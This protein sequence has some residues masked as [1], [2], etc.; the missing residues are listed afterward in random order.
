MSLPGSSGPDIRVISSRYLHN[1]D[2]PS[3]HSSPNETTLYIAGP[4]TRSRAKQLEKIIHSQVNANLMLN[5]QITLNEHMLLSTCFNVLRNG[6]L[7]E[8]AW[9]DD[10]FCPPNIYKELGRA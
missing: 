2:I 6:G 5:N 9:D 4:I 8:Q 3:I 10:G 1:E 7:H